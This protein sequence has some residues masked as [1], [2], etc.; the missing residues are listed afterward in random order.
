M[1]LKERLIKIEDWHTL[2]GGGSGSPK[3]GGAKVERTVA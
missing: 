1:L 3:D 2:K